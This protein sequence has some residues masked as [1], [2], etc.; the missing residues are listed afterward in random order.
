MKL[1][2]SYYQFKWQKQDEQKQIGFIAQEAYKLFPELVS[3]NKETDLYKMN[4]AGFSTVAIKA[5]QEQQTVIRDQQ[6]QIDEL[7][8]KLE[9]LEA[10]ILKK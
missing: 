9:T 7:R 5:I 3:Y 2:P 6:Q 10:I 4:Y 1:D 8:S